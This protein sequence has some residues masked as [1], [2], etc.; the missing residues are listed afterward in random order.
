DNCLKNDENV[1]LSD[2]DIQQI[3]AMLL[4]E[5]K[6]FYELCGQFGWSESR[7]KQSLGYLIREEKVA[8]EA[9]K[10]FWKG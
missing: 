9:D 10:Y 8:A 5:P 6:T 4:E 7:T 2:S 1:Y 3:K